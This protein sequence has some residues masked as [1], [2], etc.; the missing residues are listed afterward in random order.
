MDNDSI[1]VTG[2]GDARLFDV[3]CTPSST[4][5]ASS[6]HGAAE[7]I[8]LLEAK[9]KRL[10]TEKR[11]REHEADILVDYGRSLRG[12]HISPKNATLF[13][14][15]FVERASKNLDATAEL[16]EAIVDIDS[17]IQREKDLESKKKGLAH[18]EVTVVVLADQDGPVEL[19]LTYST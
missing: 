2:L 17:E 4:S 14:D 15:G 10:Q 16:E 6:P 8:R 3:I 13:F 1:R 5:S 18:T 9:K 11:V 19:K 12:E 7:R